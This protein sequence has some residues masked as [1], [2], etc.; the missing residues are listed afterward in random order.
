M[1][2]FNAFGYFES[3]YGMKIVCLFFY[4][5]ATYYIS[6]YFKRLKKELLRLLEF[7][8]WLYP[9]SKPYYFDYIIQIKDFIFMHPRARKLIWIWLVTIHTFRNF[10]KEFFWTTYPCDKVI[11][12]LIL[13]DFVDFIEW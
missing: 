3:L 6:N 11:H 12:G 1:F 5:L 9:S 10:L 4:E 7:K 13:S 2:N 8:K